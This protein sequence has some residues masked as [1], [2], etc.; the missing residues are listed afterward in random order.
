MCLQCIANAKVIKQD[1][2]PGFSLMQATAEA[3][4]WKK[5]SFGLVECNDPTFV[6]D[7]PLVLDPTAGMTEDDLDWQ[8]EMPDGYEEYEAGA[9]RL[10]AALKCD[11]VTGHRLVQACMQVGYH[12][13]EH[14]ILGYWLLNYLAVSAGIKASTV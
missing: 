14:G 2:L 9:Q 12:P 5:D 4:G 11:P 13:K 1:V 8:P 10:E 3:E 6:F 7:G